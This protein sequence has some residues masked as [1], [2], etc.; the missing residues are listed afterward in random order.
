[1]D[2]GSKPAHAISAWDPTSRKTLHKN[3]MLELFKK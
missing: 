2:R 3:G 1:V